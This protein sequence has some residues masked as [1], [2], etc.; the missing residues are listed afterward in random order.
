MS[1]AYCNDRLNAGEVPI[2]ESELDAVMARNV[3]AG[4]LSFTTDLG[5]AVA[6]AEAAERGDP[7]G[8]AQGRERGKLGPDGADPVPV[9]IGPT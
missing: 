7:S 8:R 9:L 2:Y 1:I 5:A 4:R 3:D 6:D